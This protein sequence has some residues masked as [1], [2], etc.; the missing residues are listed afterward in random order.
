M[1]LSVIAISLFILGSQRG[2]SPSPANNV[3]MGSELSLTRSVTADPLNIGTEIGAKLTTD[4]GACVY[5]LKPDRDNE[6]HDNTTAD[7]CAQDGKDMN[8][9]YSFYPGKQCSDIKY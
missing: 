5:W 8:V 3:Q 1:Q 9:K 6:C 7:S 2:P 4:Y